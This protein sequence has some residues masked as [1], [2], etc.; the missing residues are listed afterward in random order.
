MHLAG[1]RWR[2][3]L[4]FFNKVCKYADANKSEM[5]RNQS[6][7][8][9]VY[10][11]ESF[12]LFISVSQRIFQEN[13]NNNKMKIYKY[14]CFMSIENYYSMAWIMIC[15]WRIIL[16]FIDTDYKKNIHNYDIYS[17]KNIVIGTDWISLSQVGLFTQ[18][19]GT[20]EVQQKQLSK[21]RTFPSLPL[22]SDSFIFV[23]IIFNKNRNEWF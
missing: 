22:I 10:A 21:N 17:L 2:G 13:L 7:F 12:P 11:S 4:L 23:H 5:E 20:N 19:R 14:R 18:Y 9:F 15:I 6:L 8:I 16:Y 3:I 1:A